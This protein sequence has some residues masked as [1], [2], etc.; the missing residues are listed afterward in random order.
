MLND[1]SKKRNTQLTGNI[2]EKYER[3]QFEGDLLTYLP[4][5]YFIL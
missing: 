1:L 2:L 3:L 5:K 4:S